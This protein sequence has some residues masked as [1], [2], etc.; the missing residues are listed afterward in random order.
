MHVGNLENVFHFHK[1]TDFT[2]FVWLR[3][4]SRYQYSSK[5]STCNH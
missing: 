2:K 3:L 5:C 4:V 1:I